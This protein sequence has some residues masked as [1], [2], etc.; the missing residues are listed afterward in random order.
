MPVCL[1]EQPTSNF[2]NANKSLIEVWA[3]LLHRI[4]PNKVV[5]LFSLS[6]CFMKRLAWDGWMLVKSWSATLN[7]TACK[8][9]L[10]NRS[11]TLNSNKNADIVK[12]LI[13]KI[14]MGPAN[15]VW[16]VI[17]WYIFTIN[18]NMGS[19][20][21]LCQYKYRICASIKSNAFSSSYISI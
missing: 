8:S 3:T 9:T 1:I 20:A 11:M 12:L 21:S 15:F 19:K 14:C 2:L 5:S 10:V 16:I 6:C 13:L 17:R 4:F 18:H 7:N